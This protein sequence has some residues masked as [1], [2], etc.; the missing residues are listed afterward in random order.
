MKFLTR[1]LGYISAFA[2]LVVWAT[3]IL[4]VISRYVTRRPMAFLPEMCAL[5]F[6]VMIFLGSALVHLEEGHIGFDLVIKVLEA[7]R[8]RVADAINWVLQLS[9]VVFSLFI[10]FSGVQLV[11]ETWPSKMPLTGISNGWKYT[12]LPVG[13]SIIALGS[14]RLLIGSWLK[15]GCGL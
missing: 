10:L 5:A 13:S 14:L 3:T 12:F 1:I 7:R 6:G 11:A 8:K 2:V 4:Q 15:R 9:I